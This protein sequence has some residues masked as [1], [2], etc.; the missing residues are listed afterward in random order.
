MMRRFLGITL[1][2]VS[3]LS[4]CNSDEHG[5]ESSTA[6]EFP[7]F[8]Y[9]EV[10]AS[11]V[12]HTYSSSPSSVLFPFYYEQGVELDYSYASLEPLYTDTVTI[13]CYAEDAAVE[14][15]R[16][17]EKGEGILRLYPAMCWFQPD[18][19]F[20]KNLPPGFEP[21]DAAPLEISPDPEKYEPFPVQLSDILAYA[22]DTWRVKD[23][24]LFSWDRYP[25]VLIMDTADYI[26]Q[27]RF[28]KRLAFF[29][30]K[31]GF[32]GKILSNSFLEGRHGWNAHDYR[33]VDLAYLFQRARDS[34][35]P[36]NREEEILREILLTNGIIQKKEGTYVPGSGA[37]ISISQESSS[38]LRRK[39]L[40]HESFHG[41]FFI[42]AEY[43]SRLFTVW[44]DMNGVEKSLW[45][46][47]FGWMGYNSSDSYLMVNEFQ[48]YLLQQPIEE[49]EAYFRN[50]PATDYLLTRASGREEYQALLD[51]ETDYFTRKAEMVYV[52]VS[53]T[54]G[55]SADEIT[56]INGPVSLGP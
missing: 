27:S 55:F 10:D 47:F 29:V 41:L 12:K 44:D 42:N 31:E 45:Q 39:F 5:F 30:E 28:F 2:F 14:F 43:E 53:E 21:V 22:P 25:S 33:A 6:T 38:Y 4:S 34:R 11:H 51:T 56:D 23:Y 26:V 40:I 19:F 36:L 16:R 17:V 52:L 46:Q 20:L 32:I 18:G 15:L 13:V 37:I 7:S 8:P 49:A 48:A 50:H 9:I 35:F 3:I 54:T 24:E 1:V